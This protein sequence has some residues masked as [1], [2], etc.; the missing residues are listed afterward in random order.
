[1]IATIAA[2]FEVTVVD[3]YNDTGINRANA[4][5]YAFDGLHFNALG[6]KKYAN[7]FEIALME[8]FAQ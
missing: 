5:D 4:N 3:A 1:M 6:M 8:K 7:A 2:Y